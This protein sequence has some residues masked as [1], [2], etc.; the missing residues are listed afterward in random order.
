MY[1][2]VEKNGD[3]CQ[4]LDTEDGVVSECSVTDLCNLFLKGI[5]VNG[6]TYD[7]SKFVFHVDFDD[8]DYKQV[9]VDRVEQHQIISKNKYYEML[10]DFCFKAKNLYNHSN[11]IHRHGLV[12]NNNYK[13]YQ[14][15][16][17]ELKFDNEFPDYTNMPTHHTAIQVLR[18]LDKNWKSFFRSIKDYSSNPSKYKGRPKPPKYL[19]KNGRFVLEIPPENI[20]SNIIDNK[21]SFNKHFNG[22]TVH[23]HCHEK[24]GYNGVSLVRVVPRNGYLIIEVCYKI[25]KYVKIDKKCSER[26]ISIDLGIDNFAAIT[27][28]IGE[29]P[30][31]INGRGLKSMNQFYNK[32]LARLQSESETYN[33]RRINRLVRKRNNKVDYFMHKSSKYIVNYCVKHNIDTVVMGYNKGWKDGVSLGKRVNQKFVQIPYY[34]FMKMLEYKCQDYGIK[35]IMTEESYTSGTSFLDYEKPIRGSYNKLRRVKRGLFRSNS[36]RLINADIN[37]SYQIAK[38]VFENIYDSIEGIAVCPVRVNVS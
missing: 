34:K 7:L 9:I 32:E 8:S 19:S 12:N 6:F 36:G 18:R 33:T 22:F 16:Y 24:E 31:I 11:Y 28:N 30:V 29:K 21:L 26:I 4:V 14:T 13:G 23:T 25:T 1:S 27:N 37:A 15:L 10:D 5:F 2:I 17:K 35:F 20:R 3:I 38:K